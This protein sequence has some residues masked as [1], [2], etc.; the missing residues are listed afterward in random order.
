VLTTEEPK[1]WPRSWN[2][3]TAGACR[4]SDVARSIWDEW[5]ILWEDSDA[6]Y[7]GHASFLAEHPTD[8]RFV[9]YRWSYGSCSGCDS[10][11]ASEL[12][13]DAIADI[14]RRE[15]TW[16]ESY[17]HLLSWLSANG[18]LSR[19]DP[20]AQADHHA[21]RA[22]REAMGIEIQV[23][24]AEKLRHAWDN[25]RCRVPEAVLVAEKTRASNISLCSPHGTV[26]NLPPSA[27]QL[28]YGGKMCSR[29]V[30]H[31]GECRLVE[32][33]LPLPARRARLRP[34]RSPW[35]DT[36]DPLIASLDSEDYP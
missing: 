2:D 6:D 24:L 35:T 26:E 30:A 36:A 5:K 23:E 4:Y 31:K 17:E 8:G 25:T 13:D 32:R 18:P 33:V 9:Y 3:T 19:L 34:S 28:K 21:V 16:F 20:L 1:S 14:M 27:L 11:E 10:W 29:Y 22:M 12:T 7:Q 15:A